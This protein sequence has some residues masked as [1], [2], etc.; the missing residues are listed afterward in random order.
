VVINHKI[1]V[2]EVHDGKEKQNRPDFSVFLF[3][4]VGMAFAGEKTGAIMMKT[5]SVNKKGRTDVKVYLDTSGN[6]LTDTMLGFQIRDAGEQTTALEGLEYNA[7]CD[8][9]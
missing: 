7:P 8:S 9:I 2:L 3:L 4:G 5:S 1:F 6:G